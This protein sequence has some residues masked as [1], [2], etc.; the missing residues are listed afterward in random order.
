MTL[1]V[2]VLVAGLGIAGATAG[3]AR[4]Q[5]SDPALVGS[6]R[7]VGGEFAG[8]PLPSSQAPKVTLA[9]E[10]GGRW[11]DTDGSEATW[12]ADPSASPKTLDLTYTAGRDTG[13]TQLCVYELKADRLSIAFGIPG[14]KDRPGAVSTTAGNQKVI[15]LILERSK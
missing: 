10:P 2:V 6:W 1:Q 11:R 8:K 14:G 5:S 3:V 15:L 13:T 7:V 12:K 9:F 4:T